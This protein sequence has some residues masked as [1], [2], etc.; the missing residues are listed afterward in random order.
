MVTLEKI[1]SSRERFM[2]LLLEAD[3]AEVVVRAYIDEGDLYAVMSDAV[4]VGVVLFIRDGDDLEIK[5]LALAPEH[6]GRGIGTAVLGAATDLARR[7]G[8]SRLIVGTSDSTPG[9]IRFYE[10]AGFRRYGVREGFFD[11]YPEPIWTDGVRARDMVMLEIP[12][13]VEP[14]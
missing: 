13:A 9:T 5:N 1:E 14:T 4:E 11:A 12:L 2:P 8:A 10:R 6:R 7:T 3:E